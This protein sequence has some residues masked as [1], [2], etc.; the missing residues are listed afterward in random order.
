MCR[1]VV[2]IEKLNRERIGIYLQN[3]IRGVT[4]VDFDEYPSTSSRCLL[5]VGDCITKVG[6]VSVTSASTAA[7]LIRRKMPS[8]VLEIDRIDDDMIIGNCDPISM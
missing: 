6:S 5:Q 4:I 3:T 7:R 1:S 8:V 2:H